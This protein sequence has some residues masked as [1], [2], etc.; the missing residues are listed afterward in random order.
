MSLGEPCS[1][2]KFLIVILGGNVN[3]SAE[4][5]TART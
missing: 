5:K 3:G 2:Q 4:E 1:K